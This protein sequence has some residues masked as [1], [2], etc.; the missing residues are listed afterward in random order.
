MADLNNLIITLLG[1]NFEQEKKIE[2]L[3]KELKRLRKETGQEK[4]TPKR[5]KRKIVTDSE[6]EDWSS[7]IENPEEESSETKKERIPR[8]CTFPL[9]KVIPRLR[10]GRGR[11]FLHKDT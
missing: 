5:K 1:K 2:S 8:V 11:C 4:E 6:D 9:C 7:E 10:H 3:E